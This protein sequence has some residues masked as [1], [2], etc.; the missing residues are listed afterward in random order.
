MIHSIGEDELQIVYNKTFRSDF[1]WIIN[2]HRRT[3]D[4][5]NIFILLSKCIAIFYEY[6]EKKKKNT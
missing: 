2:K 4:K 5:C 6:R 1:D 3:S